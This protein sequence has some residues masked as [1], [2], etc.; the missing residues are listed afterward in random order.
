MSVIN[1]RLFIFQTLLLSPFH[2]FGYY[3]PS[4]LYKYNIKCSTLTPLTRTHFHLPIPLPSL[5][6]ASPKKTPQKHV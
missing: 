2:L 5:F 1:Y 4:Y 6:Q 3:H